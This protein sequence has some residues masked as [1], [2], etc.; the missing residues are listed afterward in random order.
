LN[1]PAPKKEPEALAVFLAPVA[2]R[3]RRVEFQ[4]IW[5]Y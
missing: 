3:I 1:N 4:L 2:Q 5:R